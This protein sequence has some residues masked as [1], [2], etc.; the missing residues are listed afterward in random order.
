MDWVQRRSAL[1]RVVFYKVSVEVIEV[2]VWWVGGGGV[3]R[4]RPPP[5]R[6]AGL[7]ELRPRRAGLLKRT[8]PTLGPVG[9][10]HTSLHFTSAGF[11]LFYF[12]LKRNDVMSVAG[13]FVIE[14]QSTGNGVGAGEKGTL[15][16]RLQGHR[17]C[18]VERGTW[19]EFGG[20]LDQKTQ[21][22][23]GCGCPTDR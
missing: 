8:G 19:S 21:S 20:L 12:F 2:V 18:A 6:G 11:V 15:P 14:R 5:P 1:G 23:R 7:T 16:I 17:R 13:G 22:Y 4:P 3:P 10:R 9:A